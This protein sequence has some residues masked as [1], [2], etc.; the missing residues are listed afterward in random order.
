MDYQPSKEHILKLFKI[1]KIK[2]TIPLISKISSVFNIYFKLQ[3]K[4]FK[5]LDT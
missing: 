2:N 4:E 3:K 1:N 5:F